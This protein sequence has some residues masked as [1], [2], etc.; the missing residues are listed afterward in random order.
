MQRRMIVKEPIFQ[1]DRN[2]EGVDCESCRRLYESCR[3]WLET[4]GDVDDFIFYQSDSS[5][6]QR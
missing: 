5:V 1:D 4:E 2:S 3:Q 6:S